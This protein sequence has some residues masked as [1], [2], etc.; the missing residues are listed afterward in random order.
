MIFHEEMEICKIFHKEA[1]LKKKLSDDE[2]TT[3]ILKNILLG[4]QTVTSYVINLVFSKFTVSQ[5][6]VLS[7][8]GKLTFVSFLYKLSDS[9]EFSPY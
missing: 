4:P 1:D 3:H 7:N 8:L 6:L 2:I 9:K 5:I